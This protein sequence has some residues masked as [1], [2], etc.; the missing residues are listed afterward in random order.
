MSRLLIQLSHI[1]HA[2]GSLPIFEDISLSIHEGDVF[3]LIGE[4][5]A[6]KTTLLRLLLDKAN[7]IT[8]GYLPQEIIPADPTMLVREYLESGELAGIAKQMT[9]CLEDPAR[10][11]EWAELHEEYEKKGGYRIIPLEKV[12]QGLKVD[13]ALLNVPLEHLSSGQKIRVALA[14]ALVN[15]PDLLLLDEPTN[16]LDAEMLAWLEQII[17][18]RSGATVIVSHDRK[19]LNATCNH[20]IELRDGALTCYGGNYDFYLA[21]RE[22]L[23]ERQ[24]KEYELEHEEKKALKQKI[25]AMTFAKGKAAPPSDRNI[26]A[27]DYRGGNHQK[28]EQRK[29]DE[30]KKRLAEIEEHPLSHPKPKSI[31]GLRFAPEPLASTVAIELRDIAY[32]G[33]FA[34]VTKIVSKGDRIVIT[35]PNGIGKTTLLRCIAGLIPVSDGE[36]RIAPTGKIG[37]L[38]Q[39]VE[40]LPIDQT[41]LEYFRE[42]FQLTEEEL[43]S[44]L[45]KSAIG[46]AELIKRPFRTMS[47]GQRK[48]LMLLSLIL[49]RPN[50]L[51]L[52]EPTNHLDFLTLEALEKALLTFEGAVIV[53]SHDATLIDRLAT[54]VWEWNDL[55]S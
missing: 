22:R 41:P 27:Y 48:R 35:G 39:E 36:I 2:F 4:N 24:R 52:D 8:V 18:E 3:A 38:D 45:H 30:L 54:E 25:K 17:R 6:G 1:S 50:I 40:L 23:L 37:Y 5:G 21:E 16:H 51:L 47:V 11:S 32:Q 7:S 33:L 46:G 10:L 19:F 12:L 20:L 49:D 53:V 43:R 29:L 34:G 15:N 42:R 31:L 55:S 26:M 28:S 44:E 14:K 9:A 13:S